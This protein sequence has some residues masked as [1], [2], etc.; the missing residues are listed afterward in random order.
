MKGAAGTVEFTDLLNLTTAPD[1]TIRVAS[2]NPGIEVFDGESGSSCAMAKCWR[3]RGSWPFVA[4]VLLRDV[5]LTLGIT[6]ERRYVFEIVKLNGT[7]VTAME[8]SAI[9]GK[10]CSTNGSDRV[11]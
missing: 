9:G 8:L 11:R 4:A 2:V 1:Q 6:E 3:Y 10:G 5:D 7:F